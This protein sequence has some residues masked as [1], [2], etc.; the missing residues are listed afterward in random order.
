[1]AAAHTL[2]PI[3]GAKSGGNTGMMGSMKHNQPVHFAPAPPKGPPSGRL[4]PIQKK[5]K[6][7]VEPDQAFS[8]PMLTKRQTTAYRNT[9]KHNLCVDMLQNGFHLSFCELFALIKR[10]EDTRVQ[11]GPESLLWSMT[12]LEDQHDKLDVLKLHLTRAETA[13]RNGD[14]LEVYR[15]RYE[16]ARY[17]QSSNDKWLADHFFETCLDTAALV[18]D[19]GGKV[20]AEGY[21]NVALAQE[22]NSE[23]HNAAENFEAYYSLAAQ[24]KEW[25]TADGISFHT[26]ACIHLAR[27]YTTIGERVEQ[28]SVELML[29]YLNKAYNSA[30]ESHQ[31]K[32]EGEAAYRLGL[33]ADTAGEND[34]ALVHL[35]TYLKICQSTDEKEGIGKACDAIAKTYARQGRVE[36]SIEY[37]KHFVT[38]AEKSGQEHA[39]S[40]ACH[41]LGNIYNTLGKYD[42]ATKYFDKA[43]NLSRSM[44]EVA[45]INVNRVQF[46]VAMAHKML[47][48]IGS[49]IVIN[50]LPALERLIEWKSSRID[51]FDKPFP[52][53]KAESPK[54]ETPPPAPVQKE[55]TDVSATSEQQ[56]GVEREETETSMADTETTA[57]E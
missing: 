3:H 34:T 42:E 17:F 14:F 13:Q 15:A 48:G 6:I 12:L 29:E 5:K 43:Y 7:F 37:L 21:C 9:Y 32:M 41:N 1:M 4:K 2:P 27:I 45:S 55:E 19:D 54:P 40:K 57:Q 25:T 39:Y 38:V 53:P 8:Q 28:E 44:G 50:N 33:A 10:Q 30:K 35:N 11:A 47:Q 20:Q 24:N 18:T 22:E 16:L 36:E 52:E 51:D 46:G 49:H 56:E 23:F 26:D 31:E